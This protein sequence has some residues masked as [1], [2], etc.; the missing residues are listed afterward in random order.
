M[1]Q[2]IRSGVTKLK[3]LYNNLSKEGENVISYME[4]TTITILGLV[5]T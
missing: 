5:E 2:V 1:C 3:V 4:T